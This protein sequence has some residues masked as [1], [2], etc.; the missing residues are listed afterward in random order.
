MV[1]EGS[2]NSKTYFQMKGVKTVIAP[3]PAGPNGQRASMFNGLADNIAA[4]THHPEQAKKLVAF[5]ASK[6]CE[7]IT[8][9]QGVA[10]PAVQSAAQISK[11]A[12]A[13]Q[14]IDTSAFQV[15][16]D[17]H[18]TYLAPVAQHWTELQAIMKPAM[19]GIMSLK[20]DPDTLKP[21]NDRVN[22]L[23]TK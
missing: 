2:W 15:P 14:G 12:F 17:Q 9:A 22:Q 16:I 7:D 11:E 1:T 4:G 6:K 13:K 20:A 10:F 5:L 19:D 8:A 23:F 21:A 18:S 3:V